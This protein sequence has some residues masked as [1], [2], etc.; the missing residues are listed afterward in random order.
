MKRSEELKITRKQKLDAMQTILDKA[1]GEKKRALTDDE[2]SSFD[3]LKS[4]VD[5][6]E[7]QITDAEFIESRSTDDSDDDETQHQR[8]GK[9][10]VK[11]PSAPY[12]VGKAIREFVQKGG[13]HGL[14]GIEKEMHNELSRGVEG[15]TGILVP[16]HR[17]ASVN[18]ATTHAT[19]V[20]VRFDPNLSILG[21]EPL[22]RQMGLTIVEGLQ[23][24]LKLGKKTHDVAGK[25]S[26]SAEVTA[27]SNVPTFVTMVPER[28]GIT[29][30]FTKELLAQINP[31]VQA[32][33]VADMIKGCD[34]K[35]TAEVYAVA[36]AAA[37]ETAA[38]AITEA[39]FNA[40]AA[41]V[42]MDGAFA[43]DRGSFFDAK[44]VKFDTGSG[45]RLAT[46][47]EMNGVGKTWD[48]TPIYY[49]NL[50]S[51]G[52]NQQY[53]VYGAWSELWL[54]FFGGLEIVLDPFTR[55]RYGEIVMTVNR[56]ADAIIR[57][58]AAF[59]KSPDLDA[60]T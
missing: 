22:Y 4:E 12:S 54:G 28:F 1:A 58:T 36:L 44:A 24:T 52:A 6:L 18:N 7:R 15:S 39:G 5:V 10:E 27:E 25:Y 21:Y 37:T 40:L 20:D 14:T 19:S 56:L 31:A 35:I 55:A 47:G 23:G 3:A 30:A 33:I 49:S 50:F 38:G 11:K 26:E 43:M 9:Y 48:G 16:F 13:I 8:G 46:Q 45:I 57:N 42:D 51:D 32:A 2:Q 53:V 59:V 34:R 41:A 29:D 17:S 60:T